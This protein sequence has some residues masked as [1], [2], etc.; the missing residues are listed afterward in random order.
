[1]LYEDPKYLAA[2]DKRRFCTTRTISSNA[3]RNY[4]DAEGKKGNYLGLY[5]GVKKQ[6]K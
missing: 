6:L 5:H 3:L 1:M 2:I 4:V